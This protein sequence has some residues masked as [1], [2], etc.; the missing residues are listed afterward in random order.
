[1][2]GGLCQTSYIYEIAEKTSKK[3]NNSKVAAI[4]VP[5]NPKLTPQERVQS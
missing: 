2:G 5:T 4:S 1:M 3:N